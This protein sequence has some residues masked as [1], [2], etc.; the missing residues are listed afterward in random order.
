VIG[1]ALPL[2][3]VI[4]LIVLVIVVAIQRSMNKG[5]ERGGG[6][7]VVAYLVMALAMGVAGFAIAELATT[8]FPGDRFVFD[9]AQNV[10]T[11]LAS[12]AVSAPFLVYFWRRQAGR[13]KMYPASAG[14]TVYLTLIE[15]VF[16]T[17]FVVASVLFVNGLLTDRSASAWTGTLVF[18]A[19]LVLHELAVRR[20]PPLSDANE[21]PRV[22]GS[23]IGLI[24]SAVGLAGTLTAVFG[25]GFESL[26]VDFDP[27]LAMLV[28]GLPVWAYQWLRQWGGEPSVPRLTWSTVVS[29]VSVSTAIGAFISLIA[30]TLQY[31]LT[32]TPPAS[33]HFEIAPAALG[34]LFAGLPIWATHRR[35]LG[36]PQSTPRRA[37]EYA[38]AALGLTTAVGSAIWLTIIAFDRSLLVGGSV[39]DVITATTALV[40]GLIVWR[41]FTL[42]ATRGAPELEAASWPR[43]LYHLGFGIVFGLAA[44]GS[45][46]AVLFILFRRLLDGDGTSSLLTPLA[47]FAYTGLA[48]WYLLA[49]YARERQEDEDEER[50]SPYEVTIITSHPGMIATK[51]PDQARLRVIHRGDDLGAIDEETAEAIVAAVGH[52]PSLVWVDEDGFRV[53]PSRTET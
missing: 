20:D 52:R 7:D 12:L 40:A 47:I 37:Y 34:L 1:L 31:V 39:S 18:G 22:V 5:K 50:V 53:A 28:V 26:E 27:W 42:L 51:F 15:L 16:M 3:L 23:A 41:G 36:R 32:D 33:Q 9:P 24:T 38:T 43:R 46:I 6:A 14:W 2:L 13:R 11:A 25:L 45:L 30:M 10:A 21:L 8:A 49:V 4:A 29:I 48:A 19:I 35:T 17:A 44:A